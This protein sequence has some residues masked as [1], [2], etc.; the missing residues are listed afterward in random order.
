MKVAIVDDE[1]LAR[2]RLRAQLAEIGETM[3]VGE[4]ATGLAAIDLAER[5]APD[6]LLLD[7]RMPGMDGIEAAR[8]LCRLAAPP[9]VIF[10]T[11]YDEHA[12]AA[13][14]AHAVDYLLKPIRVDRL[15]QALGRAQILSGARAAGVQQAA[16]SAR[17][18]LSAL[19]KG[20]LRVVPVSEVRCLQADQGYVSVFHPGGVLLIEESLRAL[21][22]E[23]AP[24]FL[25][26]HRNA[27][28]AVDYVVALERDRLGNVSVRLRDLD[29][30]LPVS[31]R[32][33]GQVRKRLRSP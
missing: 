21:E 30:A 24:R 4:G 31:R 25:R 16:Q 33:L 6:V 19:V 13:F 20:D 7:I 2:D 23:F 15:R 27:L 14:E 12:L 9:A 1:P 29:I 32:L 17:T 11:A 10:T 26:I 5:L 8:H 22:E 18:H 28:A 3:V